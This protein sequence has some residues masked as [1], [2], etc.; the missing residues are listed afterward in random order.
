MG[1]YLKHKMQ[2]RPAKSQ[3]VAQNILPGSTFSIWIPDFDNVWKLFED[4]TVEPGIQEKQEQLKKCKLA[5]NLN[6]KIS[7]RPGPLELVQE[8]ILHV[9]SSLEQAIKGFISLFGF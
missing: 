7:Q 4:T 6:D 3:L 9:D 5:D 2:N 8:N 1:D